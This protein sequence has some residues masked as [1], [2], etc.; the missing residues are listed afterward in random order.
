MDLKREG[1]IDVKGPNPENIYNFP[2]LLPPIDFH[3]QKNNKTKKKEGCGKH[4][5]RE[6]A[7]RFLMNIISFFLCV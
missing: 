3:S 5:K 2:Y 7:L 4:V 1:M 6:V